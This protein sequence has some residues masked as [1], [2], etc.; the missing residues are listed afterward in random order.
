MRN[1]VLVVDIGNTR[2]KAGIVFE[3]K[4]IDVFYFNSTQDFKDFIERKNEEFLLEVISSVRSQTETNDILSFCSNPIRFDSSKINTITNE[5]NTPN[6]IGSDRVANIIAAINLS[7][8]NSLIIDIGTCIKFDFVTKEKIYLGGSISPGIQL[9]YKSLNQFTGAL[10]LLSETSKT[11]MIGQSTSECIHSGVING[12][13]GEINYFLDNYSSD[14]QDL[15]VF[16]TG[17]DAHCFDFQTKNNI[18]VEKNL[19]LLGLF[20]SI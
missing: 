1:K 2:I 5:Y 20:Y 18:F 6:T 11:R 7:N 12:I 14:Y 4:L 3:D 9:R 19:T 16:V 15:T 17:G 10:P 8:S 13:Q